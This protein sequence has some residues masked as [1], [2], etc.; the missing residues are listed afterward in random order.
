MEG[1]ADARM[2]DEDAAEA[3]SGSRRF[4]VGAVEA[5]RERVDALWRLT[6]LPREEFDATYGGMLARCWRYVAAPEGECW[7]VLKSEA[8]TCA[9][10]APRVR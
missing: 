2:G 9:V 6:A 7:T 4:E 8:L 3:L 10:A 5:L 1:R